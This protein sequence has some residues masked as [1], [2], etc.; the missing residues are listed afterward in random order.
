MM[1]VSHTHTHTLLLKI[2]KK[3][4][5]ENKRKDWKALW[6]RK[7]NTV[8]TFSVRCCWAKHTHTH[9]V[10]LLLVLFMYLRVPSITVYPVCTQPADLMSPVFIYL[11]LLGK[12]GAWPR[13]NRVPM[14]A[15]WV[16]GST[17]KLAACLRWRTPLESETTVCHSHLAAERAD[18]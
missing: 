15:G 11:R 9:T 10:P 8:L 7:G 6:R 1:K 2:K 5:G 14:E 18:L 12:E 13:S 17:E 16:Q 4:W 3:K